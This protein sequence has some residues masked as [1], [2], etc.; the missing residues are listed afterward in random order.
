MA[1]VGWPAEDC[2]SPAG[3]RRAT[4]YFAAVRT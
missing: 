4:G 3:R 1:G 2:V